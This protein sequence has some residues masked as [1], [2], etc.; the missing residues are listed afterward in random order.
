[1]FVE[2]F[3]QADDCQFHLEMK[4]PALFLSLAQLWLSA[5]ANSAFGDRVLVVLDALSEQDRFSQFWSSLQG[6]LWLPAR[7]ACPRGFS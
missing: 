4:W 5:W 2:E 3:L 7:F 6:S 1:M